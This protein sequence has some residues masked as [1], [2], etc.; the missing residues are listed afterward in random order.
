MQK[1][2][3]YKTY[4]KNTVLCSGSPHPTEVV[5][6]IYRD[7]NLEESY[8]LYQNE[9]KS[10]LELELNNLPEYLPRAVFDTILEILINRSK[11]HKFVQSSIC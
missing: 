2:K 8:L 7:L 11:W 4:G 9:V 10:N 6:S 3:L 1:D 5:K